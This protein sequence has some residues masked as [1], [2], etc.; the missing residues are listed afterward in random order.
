M[1]DEVCVLQQLQVFSL[2]DVRNDGLAPLVRP[3]PRL[4][5]PTAIV[6]RVFAHFHHCRRRSNRSPAKRILFAFAG[7][8]RDRLD[9]EGHLYVK[10]E[11]R[12]TLGREER[13]AKRVQY[14]LLSKSRVDS[15]EKE[16]ACYEGIFV[17]ACPEADL[18]RAQGKQTQQCAADNCS[19]Q[20]FPLTHLKTI[21][22]F[23]FCSL[24]W[25]AGFLPTFLQSA[26]MRS[27]FGW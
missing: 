7:D 6:D 5:Y 23:W 15:L 2:D 17:A 9:V 8:I 21:Q 4:R 18:S 20:H 24:G 3:A 12:A 14:A 22:R 16:G 25:L 19:L 27:H 1:R 10:E 13:F 11:R 26:F